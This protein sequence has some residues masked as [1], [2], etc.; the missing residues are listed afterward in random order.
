MS[1]L[2]TSQDLHEEAADWFL[3]V[4]ARNASAEVQSQW[5]CWIE[6]DPAHRLA[7]E[8]IQKT[9]DAV[10]RLQSPPWPPAQEIAVPVARMRTSARLRRGIALGL[11][12]CAVAGVA[13]F[14]MVREVRPVHH[15]ATARHEQQSTTLPDGSRVDMGAATALEVEFDSHQRS[16]TAQE[17]EAYFEVAREP[18]RPFVVR[19]GPITVT[20]LGTAFSVRREGNSASVL[21]TDGLVEVTYNTLHARAAAGQRVRWEQGRLLTSSQATSSAAEL[22]WHPDTLR[23]EDE[24]LRV[25]VASLNRYSD[26]PIVI[27]SAPLAELRFTGAVFNDRAENWLSAA[28]RL[29]PL[30]VDRSD[31]EKIMLRPR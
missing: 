1:E 20:A 14:W 19:S 16:V 4:R 15:L 25:V 23:F 17:G 10:G 8:S 3:R 6:S 26:R 24:P 21:V 9:W 12:A 27:T 31:P 29:F 7:F 18:N 2:S 5:L 11:A 28:E 22:G 30:W 13:M